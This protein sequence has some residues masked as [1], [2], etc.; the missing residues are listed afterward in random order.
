MLIPVS[1]MACLL[2]GVLALGSY[3]FGILLAITFIARFEVSVCR[4]RSCSVVHFS[5]V[6][7]FATLLILCYTLLM[8]ATVEAL[9]PYMVTSI[10]GN[11]TLRWFADLEVRYFSDPGHIAV[12]IIAISVAILYIIP[13][14]LVLL[15]PRL[16]Y[17]LR[18]LRLLKPLYDIVWDPFKPHLRCWLS[19]QLWFTTGAFA[20]QYFAQPPSNIFAAL[21]LLIVSLFML[22]SLR[23][24]KSEW[25]NT[26]DSF[27]LLDMIIIFAGALFYNKS[28][29]HAISDS[30]TDH[31]GYLHLGVRVYCL[32][33]L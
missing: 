29:P 33:L 4:R 2:L 1:T 9:A 7:M 27:F 15:F 11:A 14:P 28:M 6:Q 23:P 25:V 21:I 18:F 30:F 5:T 10:D 26:F 13:L 8:E 16:S 12:G 32:P 24:Y 20:L 19:F 31:A 3:L 17:E 22:L